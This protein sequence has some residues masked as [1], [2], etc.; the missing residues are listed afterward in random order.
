VGFAATMLPITSPPS[1]S[2]AVLLP[3]AS[4]SAAAAATATTG[5]PPPQGRHRGR[6]RRKQQLLSGYRQQQWGDALYKLIS[7]FLACLGAAN[8]VAVG[9]EVGTL[10][11]LDASTITTITGGAGGG[12]DNNPVAALRGFGNAWKFR[13]RQESPTGE[14]LAPSSSSAPWTGP[15]TLFVRETSA[16]NFTGL[17]ARPFQTWT[18][19]HPDRRGEPLPCFPVDK[20]WTDAANNRG[21]Q[22]YG[23]VSYQNRGPAKEGFLFM[24]PLKTGSTSSIGMILRMLTNLAKATKNRNDDNNHHGNEEDGEEAMCKVRFTHGFGTPPFAQRFKNRH[25]AKSYLWTILRDPTLR[26]ISHYYFM[27]VSLKKTPPTDADFK[28]YL[29]H[30]PQMLDYYLHVLSTTP[31]KGRGIDDNKQ[32]KGNSGNYDD[33]DDSKVALKTAQTVMTEY[34]FIGITERFDESAVALMMLLGLE[35]GDVL[36]LSVKQAGGFDWAFHECMYVHKPYISPTMKQ[37]FSSDEWKERIRY[38]AMLYRAAN[39]SLDLTIDMLGPAT[40][41][42]NL[43]TYQSA[44]KVANERCGHTVVHRC[45]EGG[46]RVPATDNDCL[47][48]NGTCAILLI[49]VSP[50]L[51][52]I[53]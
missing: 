38:D 2:S 29:T 10:L 13:R 50:A 44:L 1:S 15:G 3:A 36:Y 53:F 45:T 21:R 9:W 20:E 17:L 42:R 43:K 39:R 34:D 19:M 47:W 24:R 14:E 33:D 18:S 52:Y 26:S 27:W 23:S 8:L 16:N 11:R 22:E 30:Y 25:R 37:Y 51:L 5:G 40:F 12:A 7:S 4:A 31:Y 48:D 6:R 32:K 49:F 46:E 35:L 28:F 41:Y